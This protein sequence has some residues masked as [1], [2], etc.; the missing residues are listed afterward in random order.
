MLG[1]NIRL[2][3]ERL[4]LSAVYHFSSELLNGVGEATGVEFQLDSVLPS[5]GTKPVIC[6][7]WVSYP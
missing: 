6:R 5:L 4:D 3:K 1:D 7:F 2:A